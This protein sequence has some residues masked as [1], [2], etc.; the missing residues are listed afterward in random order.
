MKVEKT[1]TDLGFR[2]L[3]FGFVNCLNNLQGDGNGK[4]EFRVSGV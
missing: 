3:E 2:V 4:M 1:L